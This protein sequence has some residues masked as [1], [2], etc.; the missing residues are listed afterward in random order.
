MWVCGIIWIKEKLKNNQNRKN[1][2]QIRQDAWNNML[3]VIMD[4]IYKL[5]LSIPK[6]INTVLAAKRGHTEY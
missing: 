6:S 4:N 5:K 2:W 3:F 1:V